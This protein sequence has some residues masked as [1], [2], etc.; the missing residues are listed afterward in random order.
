M[1]ADP[2][3]DESPEPRT[4]DNDEN[5]GH[6]SSSNDGSSNEESPNEESRNEESSNDKSP[7]SD[8]RANESDSVVSS[9]TVESKEEPP[10]ADNGDA[11]TP[12]MHTAD[13][14]TESTESDDEEEGWGDKA[15]D[16]E[17]AGSADDESADGDD[18]P[19]KRVGGDARAPNEADGSVH[20]SL[21]HTDV[22]AP[23]IHVH[24]RHRVVGGPESRWTVDD[25]VWT[26]NLTQNQ[27]EEAMAIQRIAATQAEPT[28]HDRCYVI[29]RSTWSLR[30]KVNILKNK[31]AAT[32]VGIAALLS[33]GHA[34]PVDT[35]SEP[36]IT[37]T[38]TNQAVLTVSAGWGDDDVDGDENGGETDDAEPVEGDETKG[39]DQ[40]TGSPGEEKEGSGSI[41][42]YLVWVLIVILLLD[43]CILILYCWY[44]HY[45]K[46]EAVGDDDEAEEE[47]VP[48][49]AGSEAGSAY[50]LRSDSRPE[51]PFEAK[52]EP[53][54]NA[55][56][57][58]N[59]PSITSAKNTGS[60]MFTFERG[61]QPKAKATPRSVR[62]QR[63]SAT[64]REYDGPTIG[65]KQTM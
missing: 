18:R 65:G 4:D 61:A 26:G 48:K 34:V 60:F 22:A 32:R 16:D 59:A 54:R 46:E 42:K 57:L 58:R 40:E 1:A 43:L 47:N 63:N 17:G 9:S 24:V 28:E 3:T 36:E 20:V 29:T 21:K 7:E 64:L 13:E 2:E 31:I 27:K 51:T 62:S 45:T 8:E 23:R 35:N 25:Y 44:Y 56:S 5:D 41:I 52:E 50:A 39:A 30:R 14:S 12:A 38:P 19:P 6:E 11:E 49:Y 53:M 33:A 15:D 55:S 10:S 37:P